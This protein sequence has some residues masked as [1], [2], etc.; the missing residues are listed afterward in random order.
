[1]KNEGIEKFKEKEIE[2]VNEKFIISLF[3]LETLDS[4]NEENKEGIDLSS[5]SIIKEDNNDLS[6]LKKKNKIIKYKNY[7][8]KKKD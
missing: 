5:L 8:K 7:L 1:M 6:L 3:Y 4:N 2:W